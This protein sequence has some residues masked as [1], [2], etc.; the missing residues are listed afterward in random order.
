MRNV[1]FICATAATIAAFVA[2]TYHENK[3]LESEPEIIFV[4]KQVGTY[5]PGCEEIQHLEEQK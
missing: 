2:I 3:K 5:C 4:T 1:Y